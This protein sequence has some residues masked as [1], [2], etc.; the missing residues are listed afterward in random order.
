MT[1]TAGGW[2]TVLPIPELRPATAPATPAVTVGNIMTVVEAAQRARVSRSLIFEAIAAG[3]LRARKLHGRTI[4][5]EADFVAFI[6]G[7]PLASGK[8]KP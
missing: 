4:I 3:E 5:V 7:L 6:E 1:T 8:R 2:T